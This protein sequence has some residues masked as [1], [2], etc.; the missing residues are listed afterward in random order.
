MKQGVRAPADEPGW[1]IRALADDG[2]WLLAGALPPPPATAGSEAAAPAVRALADAG[3]D[4]R[5]WGWGAGVFPPCEI[6]HMCTVCIL[7][8][9]VSMYAYPPGKIRMRILHHRS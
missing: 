9:G 8:G 1:P 2:L 5:T 6:R 4:I 3:L 7:Q